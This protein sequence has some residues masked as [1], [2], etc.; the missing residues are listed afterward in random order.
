[1]NKPLKK[2]LIVLAITLSSAMLIGIYSLYCLG[3]YPVITRTE[4]QLFIVDKGMTREALVQRMKENKLIKTRWPLLIYLRFHNKLNHFKTGTYY[5]DRGI[6]L[7]DFLLRLNQGK[8]AQF[9]VQFVEG[10]KAADWII[11]LHQT[12]MVKKEI[13]HSDTFSDMAK[14]IGIGSTSIEG[15]FYPDTY[16]YTANS[17]DIALLKRA[18]SRMQQTL[19][20]IWKNRSSGL[21][22]K[23]PYE[24]LIMASLIEKETGIGRE[25]P[26]V[27][28]VFVN[29]LNRNMKLQT[30]PTVIYGLGDRYEGT[31]RC[32]DLQDKN[33][34]N[35][36]LIAGLPPTPI[37]MPSY[38][39]LEAA[40]HPANTDYLY[41]VADGR[42]GHHFS[43]TLSHHN[44]AVADYLKRRQ[45]PSND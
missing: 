43:S 1:M 26:L 15:W 33:P 32:Q 7:H 4:N 19:M 35:T 22:Y 27:A 12:P 37:A 14:K 36:Y 18:Y 24:L 20:Q 25:R 40:A 17:T 10:T 11:K 5:V 30:D 41:F 45:N 39:A 34:Y 8:E 13:N 2:G 31:L 21:P 44:K 38:A 29:R 28:S 3:L 23:T 42:N 16:H 6:T 9:L